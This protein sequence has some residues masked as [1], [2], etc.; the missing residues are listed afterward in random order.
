MMQFSLQ[1]EDK[2]A[3][4]CLWSCLSL[5]SVHDSIGSQENHTFHFDETN[6]HDNKCL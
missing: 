4:C 2:G 3:M 1:T 6:A 5:Q